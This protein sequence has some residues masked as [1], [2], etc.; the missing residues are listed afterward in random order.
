M[1]ANRLCALM[2]LP[3]LAVSGG[4]A[5]GQSRQQR[6]L[7]ANPSVF[8]AAD[9]GFGRLA[10]DRGL[11]AAVKQY[12]EAEAQLVSPH[13]AQG[14]VLAKDWAKQAPSAF[15]LQPQMVLVSCD[16]N[17]A[18]TKGEWTAADQRGPYLSV[19]TRDDKGR[20]KWRVHQRSLRQATADGASVAEADEDEFIRSRQ[21]AC[22]PKA[23]REAGAAFGQ[24]GSLKWTVQTVA[25][26]GSA[27]HVQIWNG[28]EMETVISPAMELA[29]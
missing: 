28:K 5:H 17:I 11:A 26:G 6:P 22:S 8:V 16:G 14:N 4:I 10:Q 24:D 7:A 12:G 21:A 19:W 3:V 13:G 25:G 15:R 9:I 27:L 29:L 1:A 20:L 18:V 23:A 2:L